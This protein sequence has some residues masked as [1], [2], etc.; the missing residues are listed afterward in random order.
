MYEKLGGDKVLS[1]I[2]SYCLENQI[3]LDS[4]NLSAP[5]FDCGLDSLDF[6]AIVALLELEFGIDPF[7][8]SMEATYPASLQEF[9]DA[10]S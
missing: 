1:V 10:Y 2:K 9:L 4:T 7:R 8:N 6:A 3:V 5:I